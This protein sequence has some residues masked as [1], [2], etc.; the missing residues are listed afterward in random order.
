MD[1]EEPVF[2]PSAEHPAHYQSAVTAAENFADR[3]YGDRASA[4]ATLALAVQL[5]RIADVIEF[6]TVKDMI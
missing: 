5:A 2:V 6:L 3:G 1:D 4:Y